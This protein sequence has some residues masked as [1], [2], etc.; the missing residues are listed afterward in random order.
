MNASVD[1]IEPVRKPSE[2]GEVSDDDTDGREYDWLEDIDK[3]KDVYRMKVCHLQK[4]LFFRLGE[5]KLLA[6][7]LKTIFLIHLNFYY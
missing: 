3:H 6:E 5:K 2:N 1:A 7:V 4:F